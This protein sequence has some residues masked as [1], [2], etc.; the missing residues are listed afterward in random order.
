MS[1]FVGNIM[2]RKG[3]GS[4]DSDNIHISI[5]PS[6]HNQQIRTFFEEHIVEKKDWY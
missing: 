2:S 3:L 5:H 6:V 1:K 4:A